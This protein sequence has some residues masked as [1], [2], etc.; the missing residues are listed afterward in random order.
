MPT[1]RQIFELDESSVGTCVEIPA[2][3]RKANLPLR[4]VRPGISAIEYIVETARPGEVVHVS[5]DAYYNPYLWRS[6]LDFK[7]IG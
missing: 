1:I 2:K 3:H 4:L 7:A 6:Y 5:E